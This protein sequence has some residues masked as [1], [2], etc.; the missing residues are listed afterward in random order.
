MDTD[1]LSEKTYQAILVEAEKFNH[2]LTLRFGVLSYQCS[3]EKEYIQKSIR[4]INAI[5]KMNLAEIDDMF[6]GNPPNKNE[7]L[8][9]LK[10]IVD[11]IKSL[12]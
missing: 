11:N 1:E 8:K 4:L 10:R 6:F 3:D 2:D 5:K 12:D 7:L 9:A